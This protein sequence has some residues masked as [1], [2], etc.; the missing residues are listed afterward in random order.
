M[1]APYISTC[2]ECAKC[3]LYRQRR[4]KGLLDYQRWWCPEWITY[5]MLADAWGARVQTRQ[6]RQR[7]K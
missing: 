6:L 1:N 4:C 5:G 2:P 7:D 3:H